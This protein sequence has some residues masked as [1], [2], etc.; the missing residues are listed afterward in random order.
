M[1]AISCH[2]VQF[3]MACASTIIALWG[4]RAAGI[5]LFAVVDMEGPTRVRQ[6]FAWCWLALACLAVAA[7]PLAVCWAL[8]SFH[9]ICKY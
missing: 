1:S 8:V 7:I 4:V 6:R 3:F 9:E 2:E 5:R